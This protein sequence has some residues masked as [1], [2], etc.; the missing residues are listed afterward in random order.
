MVASRFAGAISAP[1]PHNLSP[2]SARSRYEDVFGGAV[3]RA[4]HGVPQIGQ[5]RKGLWVDQRL[6]A[7]RA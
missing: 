4:V 2:V 1:H 3:G 6:W 5:L 7:P